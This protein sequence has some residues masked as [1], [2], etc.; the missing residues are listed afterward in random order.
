MR[1]PV[2]H[3]E[4]TLQARLAPQLCWGAG[5]GLGQWLCP[6]ISFL[7]TGCRAHMAVLPGQGKG[8]AVPSPEAVSPCSRRCRGSPTS[9]TLASTG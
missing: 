9:T 7:C 8:M 3:L 6:S 4:E 2:V 5:A 1:L